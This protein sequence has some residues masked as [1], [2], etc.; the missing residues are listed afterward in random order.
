MQSSPEQLIGYTP[1]YI[2]WRLYC[3]PQ[4]KNN[5]KIKWNFNYLHVLPKMQGTIFVEKIELRFS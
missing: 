3:V 1:H 2:T 5:L 4:Q